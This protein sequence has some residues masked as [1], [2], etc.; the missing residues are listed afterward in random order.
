LSG[1]GAANRGNETDS[2]AVDLESINT[3]LYPGA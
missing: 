1:D 2:Y 3:W